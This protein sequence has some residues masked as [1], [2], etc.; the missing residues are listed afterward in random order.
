MSKAKQESIN[1]SLDC[2]F[3]RGFEPEEGSCAWCDGTGITTGAKL[4]A[5]AL[6]LVAKVAEWK[7][8]ADKAL[9]DLS[10][11]EQQ[12]RTA[13]LQAKVFRDLLDNILNLTSDSQHINE[14][15]T[16]GVERVVKERNALTEQLRT[17]LSER[18][19]AMSLPRYSAY[20]KALSEI[21]TITAAL[22][23]AHKALAWI[24][25]RCE[26]HIS[27]GLSIPANTDDIRL[28]S[29]EAL[30]VLDKLEVKG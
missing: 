16:I 20:C 25:Q 22:K 17:A 21:N 24:K 18:D 8:K 29:I 30:A 9:S 15:V 6:K 11:R 23:T 10:Q 2:P 27:M 19:E 1:P 13:Q 14:N 7:G 3:C 26:S 12:L 4:D 5:M 28:V